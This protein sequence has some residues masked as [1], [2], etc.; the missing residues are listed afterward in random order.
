[1]S[2]RLLATYGT[3]M[4]A[5]DGPARLGIEEELSYVGDARW[6]GR[7]YDLG[8]F[9]GAV[10]GDGE[11]H[12]ELVRLSSPSVW[13]V[14]DDYEGYDP[15]APAASLFVRRRVQLRRPGDR[16]AWVYWFNDDPTGAPRVRSGDWAA[17]VRARGSA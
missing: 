7:L 17:Y 15:D 5:F 16:E 10:P 9:P 1:M 8:R 6:G 12:G 4:R 2:S 14:L 3:L 11:V 13:A